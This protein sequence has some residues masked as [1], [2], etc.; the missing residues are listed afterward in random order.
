MRRRLLQTTS[1]FKQFVWTWTVNDM[2]WTWTIYDMFW[3]WIINDKFSYYC[4]TFQE[5]LVGRFVISKFW[6]WLWRPIFLLITSWINA[7]ITW[8]KT[9][10]NDNRLSS[11]DRVNMN[12]KIST[13]IWAKNQFERQLHDLALARYVSIT[14][15]KQKTETFIVFLC[16]K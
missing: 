16:L 4:V 3:T 7:Y 12:F 15:V 10:T 14:Y 1:L 6:L 11:Y 8:F 13:Q 2:I 9:Q 5:L